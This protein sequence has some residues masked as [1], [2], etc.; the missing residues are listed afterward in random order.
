[1][2]IS[3]LFLISAIVFFLFGLGFFLV[4]GPV[5]SFY[6]DSLTQ[7][8]LDMARLLGA[9]YLGI[10]ALT[11]FARNSQPSEARRAIVIGGFVIA[12]LGLV[13]AT[14]IQF[15]GAVNALGW[16]TVIIELLFALAYGYFAF[17][18][19]DEDEAV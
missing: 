12:A 10:A 18:K 1:M 14:W 3:N 11:W 6:H 2:K 4:P 8:A 13:A 19:K 7:E 17:V 9:A 15:S 5:L 16:S